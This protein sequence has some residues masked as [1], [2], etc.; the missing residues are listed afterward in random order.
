MEIFIF[1]TNKR[2]FFR[3][4][5]I[6]ICIT[7]KKDI[8]KYEYVSL[9]FVLDDVVVTP[10]ISIIKESKIEKNLLPLHLIGKF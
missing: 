9:G 10:E 7:L 3:E 6:V 1:E 8:P 4:S 5:P 2:V